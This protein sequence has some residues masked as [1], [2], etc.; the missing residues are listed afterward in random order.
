MIGGNPLIQ[1]R[2]VATSSEVGA[3]SEELS[4]NTSSG[5]PCASGIWGTWHAA[6][7]A[8][9]NKAC[10]WGEAGTGLRGSEAT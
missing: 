6:H 5:R 2:T 1:A 4:L 10:A 7:P 8:D 3:G 9:A